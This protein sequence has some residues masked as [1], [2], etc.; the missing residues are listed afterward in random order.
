MEAILRII[1]VLFVVLV[2]IFVLIQFLPAGKPAS[3]PPVTQE[4]QWDSPQTRQLA[5]QA[6]FDCHSNETQ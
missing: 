3:N 6:F 4:P 5:I 2:V 1:I